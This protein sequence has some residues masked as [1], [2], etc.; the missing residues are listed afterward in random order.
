MTC[1]VQQDPTFASRVFPGCRAVNF[2]RT[3]M[4]DLFK[5]DLQQRGRL[6]SNQALGHRSTTDKNIKLRLW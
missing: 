4:E 3:A 2:Q 5:V 1:L 6:V